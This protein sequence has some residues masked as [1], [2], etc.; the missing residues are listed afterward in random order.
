[1]GSGPVRRSGL[2]I[3]YA[4]AIRNEPLPTALFQPREER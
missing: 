4:A 1:M 2:T 3:R